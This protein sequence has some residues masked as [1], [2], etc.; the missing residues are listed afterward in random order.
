[1]KRQP[2]SVLPAA[3]LVLLLVLCLGACAPKSAAERAAENLDLVL[4]NVRELAGADSHGGFHG[5]GTTYLVLS[6]P[7]SS[8]LEQ[9]KADSRW[10]PFPMDE[11]TQILAYGY[12]NGTISIGP[13]LGE[14]ELPAI[15]HGY[16]RLI[17]RHK[18][19]DAVI[20]DRHSF[21]FTLGIYDSDTNTLYYCEVDT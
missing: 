9:I 17:D 13:Y 21:N 5:D 1:M 19:A 18:E 10:R 4:P 20:L 6:C 11:I 7:D 12:D 14:A 15:Q 3:A 8:A 2:S 16:Y